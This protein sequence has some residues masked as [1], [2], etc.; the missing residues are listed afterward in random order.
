MLFRSLDPYRRHGIS[1]TRPSGGINLW[2]ALPAG[3]TG[4]AFAAACAERG[5]SV[6][7][8]S[9][10]RYG[11]P[12]GE[13]S[14]NHVR[15]SFGSVPSDSLERCAG[16]IGSVAESMGRDLQAFLLS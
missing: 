15:I 13:E 3:V 9:E 5:C 1:W 12:A 16:I 2:L 6:A 8:E 4:R 11:P 14:D 7:A 10:F